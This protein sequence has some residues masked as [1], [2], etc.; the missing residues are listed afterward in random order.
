MGAAGEM[1]SRIGI[2]LRCGVLLV[3]TEPHVAALPLH[4]RWMEQA[5]GGEHGK[6]QHPWGW[7]ERRRV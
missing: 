7:G 2:R 4:C 3:R 6:K 1:G 5:R